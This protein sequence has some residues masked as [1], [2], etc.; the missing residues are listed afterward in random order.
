MAWCFSEEDSF[1]RVFDLGSKEKSM[2]VTGLKKG[3]AK[4][5]LTSNAE[6]RAKLRTMAAVADLDEVMWA[7]IEA[8]ASQWTDVKPMKQTAFT[9]FVTL[10]DNNKGRLLTVWEEL[11]VKSYQKELNR[12]T[13]RK[14]KAAVTPNTQDEKTGNTDNENDDCNTATNGSDERTHSLTQEE[15]DRLKIDNKDHLKTIE[16]LRDEVKKVC[17]TLLIF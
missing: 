17:K 9:H 12:L 3:P 10:D 1:L 13:A 4:H 8:L 14:M 5:L 2:I 16:K 6:A 15:F 11:G 7:R